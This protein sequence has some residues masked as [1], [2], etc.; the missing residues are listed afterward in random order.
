MRLTIPNIMSMNLFGIPFVGGD[1][2]GFEYNTTEELCGRWTQLG[3]L[4]PFT[5]NHNTFNGIP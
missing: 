2:C 3:V 4:Y 5:R 1:I